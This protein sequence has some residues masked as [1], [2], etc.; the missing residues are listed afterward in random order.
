ME[1][2]DHGATFSCT[3]LAFTNTHGYS[4][5]A[6]GDTV[7]ICSNGAIGH[8]SGHGFLRSVGV[9]EARASTCPL[10]WRTPRFEASARPVRGSSPDSNGF[11]EPGWAMRGAWSRAALFYSA[12]TITLTFP[13][14]LHVGSVVPHDV[15]DPLLSTALVWWNTHALPLTGRWW[16][17]F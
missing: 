17:G 4:R 13:L 6:R 2:H 15:G 12:L 5:N 14:I 16:N 1:W 11:P 3:N 10:V 7:G 8:R 9:W